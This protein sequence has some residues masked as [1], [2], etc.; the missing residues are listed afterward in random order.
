MVGLRFVSLREG[1]VRVLRKRPR[2]LVFGERRGVW[3]EVEIVA[4]AMEWEEWT[5]WEKSLGLWVWRKWGEVEMR[6]GEGLGGGLVFERGKWK[7]EG[8]WWLGTKER[9]G[10][11]REGRKYGG[12]L[13][14]LLR[15]RCGV[16]GG[17][18]GLVEGI[19]MGGERCLS[20]GIEMNCG[21][22]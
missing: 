18:M 21:V 12:S 10:R 16:V 6:E 2:V 8:G 9:V 13:R 7:E 15:R 5:G 22:G 11:A 17:E 20:D 4:E 1:R 19:G 3:E 14:S